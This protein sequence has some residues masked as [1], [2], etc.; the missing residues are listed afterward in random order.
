MITK[1]A[2]K[3]CPTRRDIWLFLKPILSF[4]PEN[5]NCIY[6]FRLEYATDFAG[7]HL[8]FNTEGDL[9]LRS[10]CIFWRPTCL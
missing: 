9:H 4:S 5:N 10:S 2:T 3:V 1:M 8:I 6:F 7:W